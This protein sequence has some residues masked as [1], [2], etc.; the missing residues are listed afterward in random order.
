M[1]ISLKKDVFIVFMRGC[2]TIDSTVVIRAQI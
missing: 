2:D 1:K